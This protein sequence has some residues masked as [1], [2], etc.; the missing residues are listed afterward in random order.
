MKQVCSFHHILALPNFDNVTTYW[1]MSRL[2]QIFCMK[3]FNKLKLLIK[4]FNCTKKKKHP[5]N[6]LTGVNLMKCVVVFTR[7]KMVY[8][9]FDRGDNFNSFGPQICLPRYI[10][11]QKMSTL[12]PKFEDTVSVKYI[13]FQIFLKKCRKMKYFMKPQDDL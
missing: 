2:P 3:Y 7:K 8:P 12:N 1:L 4:L 5:I 6:S 9:N 10:S 13:F 11:A